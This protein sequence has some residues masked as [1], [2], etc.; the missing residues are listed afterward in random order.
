MPEKQTITEKKRGAVPWK[1]H[2]RWL[3]SSSNGVPE[4]FGLY[5][6]GKVE[7][8]RG[9]ESGREY[10]YIGRTNNLRRRFKEHGPVNEPKAGFRAY[11]QEHARAMKYWYCLVPANEIKAEEE[12]FIQKFRPRFND[13]LN[14]QRSKP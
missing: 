3:S 2:E 5:V 1:W 14:R 9:L 6:F 11:M 8:C 13:L 7:Y 4:E 10:A 12:F